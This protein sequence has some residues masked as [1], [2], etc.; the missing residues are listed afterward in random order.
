MSSDVIVGSTRSSYLVN[1][2]FRMVYNSK[3]SSYAFGIAGPQD[4]IKMQPG[5]E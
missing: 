2:D 3:V 1:I 5:S 4:E